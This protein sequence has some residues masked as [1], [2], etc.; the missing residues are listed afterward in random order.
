MSHLAPLLSVDVG[1]PWYA[2]PDWLTALFTGGLLLVAVVTAIFGLMA[3]WAAVKTARLEAAPVLVVTKPAGKETYSTVEYV[4][5]RDPTDRA[6]C[7]RQRSYEWDEP[8]DNATGATLSRHYGGRP[9]WPH[10][11]LDVRNVG[12][13]P[14]L[15]ATVSLR[16][17]LT[18]EL[19]TP[20]DRVA[21]DPKPDNAMHGPWT[22]G[23]DF[24][25]RL[26]QQAE[27]IGSIEL[28]IVPVGET[29][30]VVIENRFFATVRLS[31]IPEDI[32]RGAV[33]N[34][35]DGILAMQAH[36]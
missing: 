10:Q 34:G 22:V 1:T 20:Y 30:R 13:S 8:L 9:Q 4:I 19:N 29:V 27:L 7:F 26:E 36:R 11:T 6:L 21:T 16:F 15:S 23:R 18:P 25:H 31:V 5:A 2:S 24:P 17:E 14:A 3:A 32:A 35:L 28:P 12:R 33:V